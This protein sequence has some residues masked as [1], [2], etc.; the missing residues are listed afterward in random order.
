MHIADMLQAQEAAAWLGITLE[1][2]GHLFSG[3]FGVGL[4]AVPSK[5]VWAFYAALVAAA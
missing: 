5:P 2:Q 4:A 1:S 3:W